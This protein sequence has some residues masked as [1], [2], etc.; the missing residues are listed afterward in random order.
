VGMV[1]K[2]EDE[3]KRR[4]DAEREISQAISA[5]AVPFVPRAHRQYAQAHNWNAPAKEQPKP[6]QEPKLRRSSSLDVRPQPIPHVDTSRAP[7]KI[8]CRQCWRMK[9]GVQKML[10]Q[11]SYTET[12]RREVRGKL[13]TIHVSYGVWR[14][15]AGHT[16]TGTFTEAWE[17][18]LAE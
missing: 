4:D 16:W 13:W 15:A 10:F 7:R 14:C 9:R 2:L 12:K 1:S 11:R 8:W 6:A 17:Q 5:Q 3:Q 18:N